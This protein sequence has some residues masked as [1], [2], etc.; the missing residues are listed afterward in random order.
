MLACF[1]ACKL[2]E[3]Y[4]LSELYVLQG[5]MC[6]GDVRALRVVHASGLCMLQML[7]MTASPHSHDIQ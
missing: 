2:V 5:C 4:V 6:F 1:K 3:L 7:L